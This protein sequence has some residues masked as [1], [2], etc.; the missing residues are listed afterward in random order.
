MRTDLVGPRVVVRAMKPTDTNFIFATWLRQLWFS[1]NNIST[2][3]K[4]TFMRL[5]HA[6]IDK[7]LK[8]VPIRIICLEEDPDVI[9]GY[10]IDTEPAY[11]YFKKSW[12]GAGLEKLL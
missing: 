8:Q 9:L 5:H 3:P 1:T 7:L 11:I 4:D 6:R 12:R 2:L 10:A